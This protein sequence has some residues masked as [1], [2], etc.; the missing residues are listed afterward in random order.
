MAKILYCGDCAVQT[1]FGRVA[2]GLLPIISQEHEVVVLAVNYWGDPHDLPTSFTRRF[3][4]VLILSGR[5]ALRKF[6]RRKPLTW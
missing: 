6:W 3:W 1:G 4:A 5:I 2:E